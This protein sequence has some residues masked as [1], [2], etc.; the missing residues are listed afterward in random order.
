M[1]AW[2]DRLSG[3]MADAGVSATLLVAVVALV[4]IGTR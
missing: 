1:W 4:M 2:V 3:V